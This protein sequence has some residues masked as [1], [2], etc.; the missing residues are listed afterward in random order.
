MSTD[1]DRCNM[2]TDPL[3]SF[4]SV[5]G[6]HQSGA[7]WC[8][9]GTD[10]P[11]QSVTR[12]HPNYIYVLDSFRASAASRT[13]SFPPSLPHHLCPAFGRSAPFVMEIGDH[14]R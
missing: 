10:P 3:T 1:F 8:R 11:G 13:P 12:W 14:V 5:P 2:G 6:S 4:G 9:V 7:N